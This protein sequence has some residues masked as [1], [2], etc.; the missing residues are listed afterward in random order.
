MTPS[1]KDATVIKK[2]ITPAE[3]AAI[4]QDAGFR[5]DVVHE[6]G[7]PRVR[8]A[9]QGLEFSIQFVSPADAEQRY[10][11]FSFHC[12]IRIKGELPDGIVNRWNRSKRFARLAR[13]ERFLYV[14]MDVMLSGGVTLDHLRGQCEI[15]DR[16][17]REF[18]MHLRE[19]AD[20]TPALAPTVAA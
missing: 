16:L 8:S 4:L 15:W 18:F 13:N 5:A 1:S 9:A 17:I 3:L 7:Q 10:S 12:P 20:E 6:N 2:S 19:H 14:T 11:D